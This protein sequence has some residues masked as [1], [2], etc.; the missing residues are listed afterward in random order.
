MSLN[1]NDIHIGNKLRWEN[2][3]LI[4]KILDMFK[5]EN[6]LEYVKV[7]DVKTDRKYCILKSHLKRLKLISIA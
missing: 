7:V 4:F 5:G 2:N 1:E 6:G 3:N